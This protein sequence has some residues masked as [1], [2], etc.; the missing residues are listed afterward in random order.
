VPLPNRPIDSALTLLPLANAI[1]WRH[2][3]ALN[4]DGDSFG[5]ACQL[6]P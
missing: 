3:K 6:L 1:A 2:R 4:P 5:I